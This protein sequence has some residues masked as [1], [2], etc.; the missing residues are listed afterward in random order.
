MAELLK[1]LPK[2][3][4]ELK[5]VLYFC[6]IGFILVYHK[7]QSVQRAHC[8]SHKYLF[9]GLA[10]LEKQ[11]KWG[12]KSITKIAIKNNIELGPEPE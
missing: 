6:V 10:N 7:I 1:F 9:D 11:V 8:P 12:N 5:D 2:G 3:V 4:F